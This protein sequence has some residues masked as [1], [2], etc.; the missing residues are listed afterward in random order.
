M[1]T[2]KEQQDDRRRER[3]RVYRKTRYHSDP[4]FKERVRQHTRNSLARKTGVITTERSIVVYEVDREQELASIK[5][6]L[7]DTQALL[8]TLKKV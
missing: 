1:K 3:E 8:Q 2:I 6:E 4:E 5:A 7:R